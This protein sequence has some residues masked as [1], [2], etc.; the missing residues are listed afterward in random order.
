MKKIT[1]KDLKQISGKKPD[2]VSEDGTEYF[3][4]GNIRVITCKPVS[5]EELPDDV[6]KWADKMRNKPAV[7]G[8]KIIKLLRGLFK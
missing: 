6:K 7:S 1:K 8:C 5:Y 4:L 3:I 2:Y